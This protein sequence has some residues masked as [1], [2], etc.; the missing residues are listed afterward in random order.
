MSMDDE[1]L[2]K[3]RSAISVGEDLSTLS[4]EELGDRIGILE[5]EIARYRVTI[6]E[7]QSSKTE[8]EAFFKK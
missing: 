3:L 4:V 2:Q 6:D 7:K 1:A 5:A 8:A